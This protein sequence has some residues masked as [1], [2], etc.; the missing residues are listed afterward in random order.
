[1]VLYFG[2]TVVKTVAIPQTETRR[3]LLGSPDLSCYPK[4]RLGCFQRCRW[5]LWERLSRGLPRL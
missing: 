4:E 1:M 2:E 5:L 3:R